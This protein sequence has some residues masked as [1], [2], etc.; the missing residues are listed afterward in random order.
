MNILGI[1]DRYP[2]RAYFTNDLNPD[3]GFTLLFPKDAP[4]DTNVRNAGLTKKKQI[5][6]T[7][8]RT[9]N[10][11]QPQ[12]PQPIM[13]RGRPPSRSKLPFRR[14]QLPSFNKKDRVEAA[15]LNVCAQFKEL[16]IYDLMG[17]LTTVDMVDSHWSPL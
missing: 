13:E 7:Q 1:A 12:P 9:A 5:Q 8:R 3:C 4:G 15:D 2:Y 10:G 11:R 14:M 6:Y 16:E 17:R